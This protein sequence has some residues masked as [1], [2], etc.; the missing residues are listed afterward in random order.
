[1]PAMAAMPY[2]PDVFVD[3]INRGQPVL[4]EKPR[5]PASAFLEDLTF[6]LSKD[7]HKKTAPSDPTDMWNRVYKRFQAR[8]K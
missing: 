1:M 5:E 6:F 4:F 8:K 7:A 3:A 2:Y